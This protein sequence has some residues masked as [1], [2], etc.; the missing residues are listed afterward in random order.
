M[1]LGDFQF[2]LSTAAY[3]KLKRETEYRWKKQERLA[4]TPAWQYVG[5]GTDK[6]N[7]EGVI[8][9]HFRGGLGQINSMREM[10]GEGEPLSLI[11][12]QGNV[13]GRYCITKIEETQSDLVLNG[14]PRKQVFKLELQSYGEDMST[15]GGNGWWGSLTGVVT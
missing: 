4:T 15:G 10:A 1:T 2:R 3:Q 12:G 8:Y 11:D 5:P 7:L 13:L 9:P 6:I 14:L